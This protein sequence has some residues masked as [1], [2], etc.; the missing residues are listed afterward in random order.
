MINCGIYVT[1]GIV[2]YDRNSI[3]MY[4]LQKNTYSIDGSATGVQVMKTCLIVFKEYI[5]MFKNTA[6]SI[7]RTLP[8]E[9]ILS[10]MPYLRFWGS[11]YSKSTVHSIHWYCS[12][13]YVYKI[14]VGCQ[15][16]LLCCRLNQ[17]Y[18]AYVSNDFANWTFFA[19]FWITVMLFGVSFDLLRD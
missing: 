6:I 5:G 4:Y 7:G 14:Y 1:Q 18:V 8:I 12:M 2:S 17:L 11:I 10:P 9:Q 3:N 19:K 13:F 15:N 16:L